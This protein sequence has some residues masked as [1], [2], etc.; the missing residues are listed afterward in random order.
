MQNLHLQKVFNIIKEDLRFDIYI[1]T[2]IQAKIE[3]KIRKL[4]LN[5][6]FKM[7]VTDV[8]LKKFELFLYVSID[9]KYKKNAFFMHILLRVYIDNNT[10]IIPNPDIIFFNKLFLL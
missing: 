4:F 10:S 2:Y 7:Y 8:I 9:I 3:K 6:Y 1:N 5:P